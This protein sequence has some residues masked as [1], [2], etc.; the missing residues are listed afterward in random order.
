[1]NKIIAKKSISEDLV[2]FEIR[3]SIALNEFKPGQYIV[4]RNDT[5]DPG[6]SF[7]IIKS[8]PEKETIT[9]MVQA[10]DDDTRKLVSLNAGDEISNIEGLFG[11]PVIVENSGTVLCIGRGPAILFLFPV[12]ASLR[13]A[14]NHIV[15]VLSAQTKE[16]IILENEIKVLSDEIVFLTDDGSFGEKEPFCNVTGKVLRNNPFNQVVAIGSPKIMKEI[17]S[18]TKKHNIPTQAVL[19]L[20]KTVKNKLNG[21]FK[22]SI[23]GS[24]KSVCVDGINFNAYYRN[25][26][27]MIKLHENEGFESIKTINMANEVNIPG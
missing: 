1:M 11:Q 9:I 5:N 22:V 24:S 23:C 7:P 17:F 21:I 19:Y 4:L 12:L 25:F 2:K 16:G 13:A 14:G 6:T 8:N 3:T 10:I 26:D 27:E 15:T 18:L 20:G